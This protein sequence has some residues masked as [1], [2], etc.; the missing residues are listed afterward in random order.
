K[1]KVG[2]VST[3]VP[4]F[5]PENASD[6]RITW[7]SSNPSIV[8]VDKNGKVTAHAGGSA[9]IYLWPVDNRAH[10]GSV[11]VIVDGSSV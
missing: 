8:S 2:D 4:V 1:M 3:L 6:K 11:E 7:E 5:H 10:P 9:V